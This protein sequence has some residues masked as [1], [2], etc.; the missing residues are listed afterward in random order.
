MVKVLQNAFCFYSAFLSL[1]DLDDVILVH[2]NLT[3]RLIAADWGFLVLKN[4][5]VYCSDFLT[6]KRQGIV[7]VEKLTVHLIA[8]GWVIL[9]S[10][11]ERSGSCAD[12]LIVNC[13][14]VGYIPIFL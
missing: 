10:K 12:F 8:E 7:E 1:N 14:V 9:V 3:V 2:E 11:N 4:F 13:H 6:T 5:L